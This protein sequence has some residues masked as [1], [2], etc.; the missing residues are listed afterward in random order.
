MM[1][2]S[3]GTLLSSHHSSDLLLHGLSQQWNKLPELRSLDCPV[4]S[5][6]HQH[7]WHP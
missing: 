6:Q 7:S 1:L 5:L 4:G 2:S 3:P